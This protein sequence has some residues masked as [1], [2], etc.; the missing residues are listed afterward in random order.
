MFD[1][2]WSKPV[3]VNSPF[4]GELRVSD[5]FHAMTLLMEGW[6]AM[7]G[8]EFTRARIACSAALQGRVKPD[9]AREAFE[10]AAVEAGMALRDMQVVSGQGAVA[11]LE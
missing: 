6:P 3:V 1:K 7:A 2:K 11:K 8:P 10:R 9:E 4:L 5:P